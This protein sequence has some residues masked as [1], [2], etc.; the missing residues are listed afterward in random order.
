MF[1]PFRGF[2]QQRF[3][4]S[5]GCCVIRSI[6]L[7]SNSI[8]LEVQ[9]PQRFSFI[10]GQGIKDSVSPEFR[11]LVIQSH[12]HRD[13]AI[14]DSVLLQLG[15]LKVQS[16]QWV[17]KQKVQD[18]LE[19]S[20]LE[21]QSVIALK[22]KAICAFEVQCHLRFGKSEI[23][24]PWRLRITCSVPFEVQEMKIEFQYIRG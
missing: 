5:K 16:Q 10:S 3:S 9:S 17:E 6:S 1:S 14:R 8:I 4:S 7:I 12:H 21:V 2:G 13:S 11:A 18:S 23:Q 24:S 22:I 15:V 20:E 19:I